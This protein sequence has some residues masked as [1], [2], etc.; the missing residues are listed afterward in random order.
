MKIWNPRSERKPSTESVRMRPPRASE[1]L[2]RKGMR[3]EWRVV[4]A[5]RLARPAPIIKTLPSCDSQMAVSWV[6]DV[7]FGN[8]SLVKLIYDIR[9]KLFRLG[10][11][12]VRYAP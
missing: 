2:K 6:K 1:A 7:D 9:L 3:W 5:A 10:N 11:A 4:A 12:W 8:L